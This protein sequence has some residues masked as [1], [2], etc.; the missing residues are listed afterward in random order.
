MHVR[1]LRQ[2]TNARGTAQR[3]PHQTIHREVPNPASSDQ[4]TG[5]IQH[6]LLTTEAPMGAI[7]LL[8]V[9]RRLPLLISVQ[10]NRD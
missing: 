5:S 10:R 8:V 1:P 9:S 3:P 4:L 7:I 6:C 2:P